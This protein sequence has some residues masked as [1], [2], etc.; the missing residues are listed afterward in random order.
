MPFLAKARI[1][2]AS[3]FA[4][5][6]LVGAAWALGFLPPLSTSFVTLRIRDRKASVLSV[7]FDMG[8]CLSGLMRT[9]QPI[10]RLASPF[11]VMRSRHAFR[12]NPRAKLSN[13]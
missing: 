8:I 2:I 13:S 1:T 5:S 12:A 11:R 4:G 10:D 7:G 9:D 6:L 3:I